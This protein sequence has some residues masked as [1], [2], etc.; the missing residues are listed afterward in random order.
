MELLKINKKDSKDLI[1]KSNNLI[2]SKY[3]ITLTQARFIAFVSSLIN[4]YDKDFLTYSVRIPIILDFLEIERKNKIYVK[5]RLIFLIGIF[6]SD[7][8][9][10]LLKISSLLRGCLS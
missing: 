8:Q 3:S 7:P 5:T 9:L 10:Y 1:Y 4:A 6:Y 2:N